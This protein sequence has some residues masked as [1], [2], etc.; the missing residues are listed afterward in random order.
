MSSKRKD[1]YDSVRRRQ[2]A[3]YRSDVR[4]VPDF[5][6]D[7]YALQ[8][9]WQYLEHG[10]SRNESSSSQRYLQLISS[11]VVVPAD[12]PRT[13]RYVHCIQ[14]SDFRR[15]KIVERSINVPPIETSDTLILVFL[16]YRVFVEAGVGWVFQFGFS[17][18][19]VVVNRPVSD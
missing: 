13:S 14:S 4:G 18:T 15:R 10:T 8:I 1:V 9:F 11:P 17:Q 19:F 16:R 12:L 3:R 5:A 6:P 7:S 2:K